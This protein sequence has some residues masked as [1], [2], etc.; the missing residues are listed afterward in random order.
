[1][2]LEV[3]NW[4]MLVVEAMVSAG[5][6]TGSGV[7]GDRGLPFIARLKEDCAPGP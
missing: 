1:M 3:E 6:V 5:Q 2:E 4:R 7:D